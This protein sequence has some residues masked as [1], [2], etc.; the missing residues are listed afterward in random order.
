MRAL[1]GDD[2]PTWREAAGATADQ[3]DHAI[4]RMSLEVAGRVVQLNAVA[5]FWHEDH[6]RVVEHIARALWCALE[7]VH[8]VRIVADVPAEASADR[9][10]AARGLVAVVPAFVQ[11]GTDRHAEV[12]RDLK[13]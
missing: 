1:W 11:V 3:Q 10:L 4:D 9:L 7:L 8:Q 5:G 13:H 12:A 6:D 2:V